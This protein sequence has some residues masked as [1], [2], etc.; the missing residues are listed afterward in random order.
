MGLTQ[1]GY[2]LLLEGSLSEAGCSIDNPAVFCVK[3][4]PVLM[5]LLLNYRCKAAKKVSSI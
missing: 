1:G 3:A 5:G 4:N 2:P